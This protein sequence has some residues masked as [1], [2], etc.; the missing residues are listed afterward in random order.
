MATN[1][2]LQISQCVVFS[3]SI[4]NHAKTSSRKGASSFP[5][6]LWSMESLILGTMKLFHNQQSGDLG[7]TGH[8]ELPAPANAT[9]Q[10]AAEPTFPQESK[11]TSLVHKHVDD[12][13]CYR[14]KKVH[15]SVRKIMVQQI[16]GWL[17]AINTS[18]SWSNMENASDILLI[19]KVECKMSG[20][21]CVG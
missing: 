20:C 16:W 17:E 21:H 12:S 13:I 14:D 11:Q 5:G 8:C 1:Y 9:V 4:R 19:A 3:Y 7:G 10:A 18:Q 15:L 6:R 2:S